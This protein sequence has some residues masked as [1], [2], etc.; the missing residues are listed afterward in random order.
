[1]SDAPEQHLD[2]EQHSPQRNMPGWPVTIWRG[3]CGRCPQC[4]GGKIFNG[5]LQV[6]AQCAKCGARLGA[7]PADDA[8][9]Y[10]AMLVVLHFL[11]LFVVFFD[12]GYYHPGI[13]MAG[14][15]LVLL[16][17]LCMAALRM[18]KGAVIG[19]LLKLGCKR[20]GL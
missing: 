10:I 5:Y 7:M 20:E 8:P 13:V 11:A 9:P 3:V 15:L 12:K 6:R 2:G 14:F 1:M 19:V 4:N 17:L 18:A 16:A